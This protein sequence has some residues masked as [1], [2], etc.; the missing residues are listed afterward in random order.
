MSQNRHVTRLTAIVP[1]TDA[2]PALERCLAAIR[3]AAAPPDE[4]VVVE[5]TARPGPAAARNEGARRARGDVLVFIDADVLVRPDV[6]RRL[7]QAFEDDPE[8][9]A[10]FGSYDDSPPAPGAVSGFRNLLHHWVHQQSP[11]PAE[12]FW[13]GLG[14]IRRD[15]F[16]AAGGFDAQRYP[17]ASVEDVE[18]GMRLA[19]AG[20]RIELDPAIQGTHLKSWTL[21][22]MVETD[23]LDRGVPWLTALLRAGRSSGALNLG[24][25]HR[26][27]TL[28]SIALLVAVARRRPV[29][30]TAAGA[31]LVVLNGSFYALLA[32]RRGPIEALLG[33]GLHAVHQLTS[34]AAV[35]LA[36][37]AHLAEVSANRRREESRSRRD[38]RRC[39]RGRSSAA[40][41]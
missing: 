19:A 15:A 37:A 14:A 27:S 17:R 5:R 12:T 18:L 1:A 31:A 34:A 33:V 2:P 22:Q 36:L 10:V 13:A 28:A 40:G 35:P 26:L 32:R 39:G 11:G 29:A 9:V 24:H 20:A 7:R 16:V 8:L 30:A 41:R 4:L 3:E 23:L 6:F 25:R 38:G 21:A